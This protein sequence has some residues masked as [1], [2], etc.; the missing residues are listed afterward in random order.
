MMMQKNM[1]VVRMYEG[2]SGTSLSSNEVSLKDVDAALVDA[3]TLNI[4]VVAV[5]VE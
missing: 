5:V 2:I 4:E 1:A 3:E